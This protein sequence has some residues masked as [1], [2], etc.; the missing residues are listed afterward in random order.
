MLV[1]AREMDISKLNP[2]NFLGLTKK[3]NKTDKADQV[4]P[5]QESYPVEGSAASGD[6]SITISMEA[7]IKQTEMEVRQELSQ[8]REEK[9]NEVKAKIDSGLYKVSAED[10]AASILRGKSIIFEELK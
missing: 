10:V 3:T 8:V 4:R 9:V 6:D 1:E 7:L 2:L 5:S